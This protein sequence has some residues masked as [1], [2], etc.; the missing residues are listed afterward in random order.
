MA[1]HDVHDVSHAK[2][3]VWRSELLFFADAGQ[4]QCWYPT[5]NLSRSPPIPARAW[6]W[7]SCPLRPCGHPDETKSA[8]KSLRP[9]QGV[10][11]VTQQAGSDE[12]G[13]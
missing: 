7:A 6:M 2:M 3:A 1:A 8:L 9:Q 11:Q 12:S 4:T 13:E 10:D 5:V